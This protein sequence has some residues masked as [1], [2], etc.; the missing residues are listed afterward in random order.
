MKKQVGLEYT[1]VVQ[2][3]LQFLATIPNSKFI[4]IHGSVY[5]ERGTPDIIG[6]IRSVNVVIE[7]KK[8]DVDEPE[9]IQKWRLLEWKN[10]GS[11]TITARHLDDVKLALREAGLLPG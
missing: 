7:C 6:C 4:N 11:V 5:T 10:A 2:P 1:S 9:Q 8:A 3:V